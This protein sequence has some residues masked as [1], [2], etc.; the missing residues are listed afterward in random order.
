MTQMTAF[1]GL[2]CAD[3]PA[4]QAT[5]DNDDDARARTARLYNREFNFNLTPDDINCDGCKSNTGRLIG[6]CQGCEIR[7]CGQDKRIDDC[8]R[9]R[10]QPC[11][12]L[13]AFHAFSPQAK[14]AFD[15]LLVK[16][17]RYP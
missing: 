10:E 2:N 14:K 7:K 6:Y 4:F 17:D 8:T 3:C 11:D 13:A 5:Q 16:N 12:R 9:C 1:C 15:L